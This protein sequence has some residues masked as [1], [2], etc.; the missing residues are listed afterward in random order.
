MLRHRP[1]I[2][3][4][5]RYFSVPL[6]DDTDAK[7]VATL[8]EQGLLP[9]EIRLNFV[10]EVRSAAVEQADSSFLDEDDI[11]LAS[12][13]TEDERASIL[14]E[15]EH[16]VLGKISQHVD[17]LRDEWSK[18]TSPEDYFDQF[19]NSIKLFA[20]ALSFKSDQQVAIR[21]AINEISYAVARMND[22]YEPTTPTSAPT[23]SSTPQATPLTNLFRDVDE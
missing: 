17:R 4:R 9:E 2:L 13:L 11:T 21:R 14:D 19:A 18:D 8:H 6:N 22:D 3:E 5:L 10:D 1:D 15:V 20:R 23:A 16:E 7:L 12:V